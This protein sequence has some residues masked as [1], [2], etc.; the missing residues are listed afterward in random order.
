MS[1]QI[2]KDGVQ[3]ETTLESGLSPEHRNHLW[4][5]ILAGG[6]GDRVSD[7][8]RAWF[9]RP[10]P[11]Q[12]CAFVGSRSMLQHTLQRSEM[13]GTRGHQRILIAR[14]HRHDARPQLAGRWEKEVILQPSNRDTLPGIFLPL[15][16]VFAR[17][18][19]ATVV[20]YPS[21]HFIYP[22][23]RF[24]RMMERAVQAVEDSPH[25]LLLIGAPAYTPEPEYGYIF[26][27]RQVWRSG[28]HCV[29]SVENFLEKP[30]RFFA[31]EA[32]S[33]GALWNT[34]IVVAKAQ[35]LWRLGWLYAPDI[36][37]LFEKLYP[38]IGTPREESVVESIYEYMPTK[39]FSEDLL[40]PAA[41][42]IA[43]LPMQDIL[44]SDWG[45]KERIIETLCR[46]G[47]KP[48]FPMLPARGAESTGHEVKQI[49]IAS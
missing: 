9:G 43:V 41:D 46:M 36:L 34:S 14:A 12:Y 6:N 10:I 38:V 23:E 24:V 33:S 30:T 48:N 5:I 2:N 16:H 22:Q 1:S 27:G 31:I 18:S 4:S 17:D 32:M 35:V 49:P 44:W 15:T 47:Q 25:L 26:P 3:V 19:D 29:R 28:N 40:T 7:L 11:K 21:D 42:R 13:L 37:K 39:N 20:I 8:I 45:R